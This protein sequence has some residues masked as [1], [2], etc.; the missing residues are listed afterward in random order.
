MVNGEYRSKKSDVRSKKLFD[1]ELPIL[2]LKIWYLD[3]FVF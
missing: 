2:S 1:I 3:F